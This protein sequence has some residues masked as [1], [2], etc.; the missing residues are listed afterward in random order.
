[1]LSVSAA[2]AVAAGP[3]RMTPASNVANVWVDTDGGSCRRWKKLVPYSDAAACSG[4]A[5]AHAVA[6]PGDV[7]R[8]KGGSYG[9]VTLI[10]DKGIPSIVFVAAVGETPRLTILTMANGS[11]HVAF[12]RLRIDSTYLGECSESEA[13]CGGPDNRVRRVTFAKVDMKSFDFNF[14]DGVTLL[15]GDVGPGNAEE[16]YEHPLIASGSSAVATWAPKNIVIDGAY[17]H[18]F[19][20]EESHTE[21]LLVWAADHVTVRDSVFRNCYST[22]SMYITE[23]NEPGY[24]SY[25]R[26]VLVENNW[27]LGHDDGSYDLVHFE[28]DCE[29]T[30]RYN[31]FSRGARPYLL[32]AR[33]GAAEEQPVS[34]VGNYGRSPAGN[35][36]RSAGSFSFLRNAWKGGACGPKDAD[37][38]RLDYVDPARD[39]HLTPR[40]SAIDRGSR[41]SYP[42]ADKDGQRRYLG[43]APDA[44]ADERR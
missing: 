25:C 12:K 33:F 18:D 6:A 27:F 36:R 1:V 9:A 26:G 34:V 31:S 8:L 38:S 35:C 21:C 10:A 43:S 7:V 30:I 19:T 28:S 41:S 44:G 24:G 40:A 16:G 32:D 29:M 14:V 15:G 13:A 3:Q 20:A 23:L 4:P 42:A 5:R 39:L 37:V 2:S 17:F 11:G 22:G